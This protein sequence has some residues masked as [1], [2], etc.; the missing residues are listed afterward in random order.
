[1]ASNIRGTY[2][3]EIAGDV[4]V[5]GYWV[6]KSVMKNI[7][8]GDKVFAE[9]SSSSEGSHPN[10]SP[11]IFVRSQSVRSIVKDTTPEGDTVEEKKTDL[12]VS[13]DK[14]E[15]GQ[16]LVETELCESCFNYY[17][18]TLG[19]SKWGGFIICLDCEE[20]LDEFNLGAGA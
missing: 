12:V 8:V 15:T 10:I 19:S 11:T 16:S 14:E 18:K 1:M 2:K 20:E 6:R 17:D 5:T 7:K 3:S 13:E 4:L 9:V